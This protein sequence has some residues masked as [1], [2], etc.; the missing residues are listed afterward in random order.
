MNLPSGLLWDYLEYFGSGYT[1]E[2][3]I[4]NIGPEGFGAKIPYI[5]SIARLGDED[6]EVFD[7]RSQ[8]LGAEPKKYEDNYFNFLFQ[9]CKLIQQLLVQ[10]GKRSNK[11]YF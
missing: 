4:R 3:D 6:N 7:K 11:I 2:Y 5:T 9:C 1:L 10:I 8:Q